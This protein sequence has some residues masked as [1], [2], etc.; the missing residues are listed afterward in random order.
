[1]TDEAVDF[2][3]LSA[4]SRATGWLRGEQAERVDE[5]VGECLAVRA[6]LGGAHR[7]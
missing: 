2:P 6:V 7:L 1:M 4:L 5:R 3:T